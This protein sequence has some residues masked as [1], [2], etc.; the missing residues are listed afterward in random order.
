M[1]SVPLPAHRLAFHEV[2]LNGQAAF[3]LRA[4]RRSRSRQYPPSANTRAGTRPCALPST[5]D[6]ERGCAV[7]AAF[8]DFLGLETVAQFQPPEPPASRDPP[9]GAPSPPK[10]SREVFVRRELDRDRLT[11]RP[12]PCINQLRQQLPERPKVLLPE[13]AVRCAGRFPAASTMNATSVSS[14]AAIRLD[15]YTPVT[16]AYTSTFTIIQAAS[17]ARLHGA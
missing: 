5:V 13:L 1:F 12:Q 10:Q 6:L 14:L 15:E 7:T 3:R 4:Q 2:A 9:P 11:C 17:A 16:Y 8:L